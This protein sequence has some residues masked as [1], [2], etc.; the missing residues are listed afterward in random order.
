MVEYILTSVRHWQ[1]V[2]YRE[3]LGLWIPWIGPLIPWI[4]LRCSLFLEPTRQVFVARSPY[5]SLM[6]NEFEQKK[7]P[8]CFLAS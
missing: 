2:R 8:S 6:D 1:S 5:S 3:K 4:V 7:L